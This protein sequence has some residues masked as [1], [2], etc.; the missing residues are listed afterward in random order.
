[1]LRSTF[2]SFTTALRGLNTAQ[3]QLDVTGQNISNV[4]TTGYTRQRADTYAS[5][6]AGY[7]DKYASIVNSSLVG[8]GSV[9]SGISQIRDP[10]LDVRFRRESSAVGEQDSKANC[11]EGIESISMKLN[12]PV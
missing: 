9:V 1:M 10:F 12:H 5:S 8:Q 7:G 6:A 2:Y 11:M 3:K 4:S